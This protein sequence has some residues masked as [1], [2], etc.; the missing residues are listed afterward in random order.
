M[1]WRTE[2]HLG[3][4]H[5]VPETQNGVTQSPSF[6]Q[7]PKS[8]TGKVAREGTEEAGTGGLQT[9]SDYHPS[10]WAPREALVYSRAFYFPSAIFSA[11]PVGTDWKKLGTW[12]MPSAN[13]WMGGQKVKTTTQTT[14]GESII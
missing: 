10:F 9:V 7:L 5:C 3:K 2:D 6:L 8:S 11:S 12:T 1:C 14:P 13:P 4:A